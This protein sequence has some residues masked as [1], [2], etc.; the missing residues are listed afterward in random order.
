MSSFPQRSFGRSLPRRWAFRPRLE[1]LE[2]RLLPAP[3]TW[4]GGA[5][6]A[7]GNPNANWSAGANWAGGI[8]PV[9][10][11]DLIFPANGVAAGHFNNNNDMTGNPLF[12]SIQLQGSGYT[13]G[14]KGITL[15]A[16]GARPLFDS[17]QTG[18]NTIS[19]PLFLTGS[20]VE[21]S[22]ALG[23][24]LTLA[25]VISGDAQGFFKGDGGGTLVLTAA[26]PDFHGAISVDEGILKVTNPQA[27]GDT[28]ND[29]FVS[30]HLAATLELD[31]A[32]S[33]GAETLHLAGPGV[34]DSGALVADGTLA[35][36][37]LVNL[38]FP[39]TGIAVPGGAT[40][41]LSG[42]LVGNTFLKQ[43]PGTLVVPSTPLIGGL[44]GGEVA[45]GI[46][47]FT[48]SCDVGDVSVDSGAAV[49]LDGGSTV[50][51]GTLN[52]L[53]SGISGA[54]AVV[55]ATGNNT[56]SGKATIGPGTVI[57]TPA[58]SLTI[59]GA[60]SN[61]SHVTGDGSITKPG[62]GTLILGGSGT[63]TGTATVSAGVLNIQN[64]AALGAT[65]AGT[66]VSGG[67]ALQLQ[68]GIS[69][70]AE[71]LSLSGTGV[72][73]TGA[74]V[75]VSGQNTWGG[76]ITMTGSTTFGSSG[77][78]LAVTGDINNGG[79]LL[80]VTGT[81]DTLFGGSGV[82]SGTGGLKKTGGG[83]LT[84]A[85]TG[86]NTYS[87]VTTVSAGRVNVQKAS[88]LGATGASSGTTVA[89][90][91]GLEVQG[92]VTVVAESLTLN[93]TGAG[94]NEGALR[95]V[96]GTNTWT[97]PIFLNATTG[98]RVPSGE[99]IV[100]GV[101]DGGSAVGL[102][103]LQDAGVLTFQG[104]NTYHGPTT[105]GG[106]LKLVGNNAVLGDPAIGTTVVA[107][108]VIQVSSSAP[109]TEPLTLNG[110]GANGEGA[111][112][113][114]NSSDFGI[115]GGPITLATASAI[116]GA[117]QLVLAGV[118]SGSP[119]VSLTKVGSGTT[120]LR[121]ANTYQGVTFVNAG[122]LEAQ[123]PSALGSSAAGSGTVVTS[124]LTFGPA[125]LSSPG[126][127][128]NEPVTLAGGGLTSTGFT[129]GTA[130]MA[131]PITVEASAGSY[132]ALG[133]NNGPLT[134]TGPISGTGD[135]VV[136]DSRSV[137]TLASP[138]GNSTPDTYTGTLTVIGGTLILNKS[139][140]ALAVTGPLVLGNSGG[141]SGTVQLLADN[142]IAS[143]AAVTL[144]EKGL[145]DLNGHNQTIG[146]LTMTGGHVQTGTGKLT[147]TGDVTA[148]SVADRTQA[149]IE[150][151]LSLGTTAIGRIFT[152]ADGP[153]DPDLTLR[154]VTSGVLGDALVKAG[155]GT[156]ELGG[157]NTYPGPSL[158]D[159]GVLRIDGSQPQSLL[160]TNGGILEGSGTVGGIITAGGTV[161]PGVPLR[162][163]GDVRLDSQTTFL[164]EIVPGATFQLAVTG[165]VNLNN[166]ILSGV[167]LF[168]PFQG[169]RFVVIANDGTDP[170]VGTFS[171]L[172][173]GHTV[174]FLDATHPNPPQFQIYTV[175]YVGGDGN[176]VALTY[177]TTAPAFH[178]R[179][180]TTPINEG[181][182]A[183]VTGTISEPDAGDTFILQVDWG[184]GTGQETY[185]FAP[186][187]PRTVQ[188][189]HRYRDDN[190]SGTP[191][192]NYTIGLH[193]MDQHGFGNSGTLTVT[194]N[195][196]PPTV[197]AGDDATIHE[198][199]TFNRQG[200]FADPGAD[201]WTGNVDYGDGSGTQ[202][203]EIEPDQRFKLH[204][205]Y[206]S[207][208][209][210]LV[211]VTVRDDDGGIGT[212]S[213]RV[214]VSPDGD[215]TRPETPIS[216][217]SVR[218]TDPIPDGPGP[219]FVSS[220]KHK[221]VTNPADILFQ[222]I[223]S[224]GPEVLFCQDS[225]RIRSTF[226]QKE[227]HP[228]RIDLDCMLDE[229]A[230]RWV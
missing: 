207:A 124:G 73:G 160:E 46:V 112:I 104:A 131:G 121:A 192:D 39:T 117:G 36:G 202:A 32:A 125:S 8:A 219:T 68:G 103:V 195:N 163:A 182:V 170:I 224:R 209:T 183:T 45:Q 143:G 162:S 120:Y 127:T 140:G 212:G 75:N 77:G 214:T 223:G 95:N 151:N 87:G 23:T 156:L 25:G 230:P 49:Q 187:S 35:W 82:L 96:S 208:G 63:Y 4:H 78:T 169:Q 181:D 47:D 53:G 13:L 34:F 122:V 199:S 161:E 167:G 106:Q 38:E 80:T 42:G 168:T 188:V 129:G 115:W 55:S 28:Q 81:G 144:Q 65:T 71:P 211:T 7:L 184:D 67:A 105:V 56:W 98:M 205:K 100:T 52:L 17:A 16:T 76:P 179:S 27:L 136:L 206:T 90:G 99:L 217:R 74:L 226:L 108:G 158:V 44:G 200:S 227:R 201:T 178:D 110:S 84:L 37:G 155:A 1:V 141:A 48:G 171:G 91:S 146:T 10:D 111:L 70:G 159:A 174:A 12:S 133:A 102:L 26:N 85:G 229:L 134:I 43:G 221:R 89:A 107:G 222:L 220:P 50:G 21:I 189:S 137:I 62:A 150:G 9:A 72:G 57:G 130:I 173:E 2:G 33:T 186:G 203:L 41:T 190:P 119:T 31:P 83:R 69:V 126:F 218:R 216:W 175:S 138:S 123:D 54:G 92:G 59:A 180:V 177:L 94:H 197:D 30:N 20:N 40:L 113:S 204:H 210:F 19:L 164:S 147:L 18:S 154:A 14:G 149:L 194:V 88:A 64:A 86:V 22:V 213:F 5:V 165:A 97:G 114:A 153:A 196:V 157:A 185:T 60:I 142:E 132:V 79:F 24:T 215:T 61:N 58:G 101:I 225:G 139:A 145:L 6:D 148:T 51:P 3:V 172:P 193:W 66:T 15:Q 191:S 152:V 128:L 176:D 198:G 166:A 93:A 109:F 135:I 118:I 116:G 29:T 228:G 11:D